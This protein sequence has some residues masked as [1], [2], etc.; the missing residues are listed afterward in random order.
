M[1]SETSSRVTGTMFGQEL[2]SNGGAEGSSFLITRHKLT[3]HN[4]H[5][6]AKAVLM[7]ITGKG[8]DEYLSTLLNCLRRMI[9]DSRFGT[10]KTI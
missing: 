1:A 4:Y 9:K 5:Q 2:V 8:K 6:W 7:F 10:P 3:G